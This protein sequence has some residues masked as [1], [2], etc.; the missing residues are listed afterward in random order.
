VLF[1]GPF[2]EGMAAYSLADGNGYG[3]IT[4]SSIGNSFYIF[5]IDNDGIGEMP[6][7]FQSGSFRFFHAE[8]HGHLTIQ[9]RGELVVGKNG[10][11]VAYATKEG[12]INVFKNQ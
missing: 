11:F 5:K 10:R 2:F 7:I 6:L 12:I 3:L 9:S 8:L 1:Q 4:A